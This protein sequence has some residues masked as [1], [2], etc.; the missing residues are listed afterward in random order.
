MSENLPKYYVTPLHFSIVT[1]YRRN[2]CTNRSHDKLYLRQNVLSSKKL[3]QNVLGQNVLR[4]NVLSSVS[5]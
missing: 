2:T 4:Q 3:R 5:T 1:S